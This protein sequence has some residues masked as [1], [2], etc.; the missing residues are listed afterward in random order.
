MLMDGEA[1]EDEML[2]RIQ[3]LPPALRST[4]YTSELFLAWEHQA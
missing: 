3:R 4:T 2:R 1:L